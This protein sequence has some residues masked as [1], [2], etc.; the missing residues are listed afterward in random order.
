MTNDHDPD[1]VALERFHHSHAIVENRIKQLKDRGL[2]R[3]PFSG[4][5]ANRAWF[6]TVLTAGLLLAGLRD[7]VKDDPELSV[8]EPRRLRYA[9]LHV[10]AW[11]VHRSRR[12]FLRLDR[13]WPWTPQLL[14]A[15]ERL[16][17]WTATP[18]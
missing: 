12:V 10:A 15:H 14:A 6:E 18:A 11:I 2:A 13:T 3:M 4:W 8:A 9:L 16:P 5:D 7:L 17:G 1:I